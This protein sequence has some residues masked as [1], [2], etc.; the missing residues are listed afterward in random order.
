VCNVRVWLH[1]YTNWQN[2]GWSVCLSPDSYYNLSLTA[3][4]HP[5]NIYISTNQSSC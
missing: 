5:M 3:N 2:N 1:Q 4:V